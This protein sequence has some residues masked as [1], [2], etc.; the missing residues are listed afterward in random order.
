[1][2]GPR[3]LANGQQPDE[4]ARGDHARDRVVDD[5]NQLGEISH[6]RHRDRDV[7][8]PVAEPVHVVSLEAGV[9][10]RGSRARRHTGHPAADRARPS[11][12][13]Q[14]PSAATPDGGDD[15][16]EDGDAADLR[17]VDRK[18]EHAGADHVAGHEHRGLQ[19]STSSF[20]VGSLA[21][22][23]RLEALDV[24]DAVAR[25]DTVRVVP[26]AGEALVPGPQAPAGTR[27]RGRHPRP[28]THLASAS[29]FPVD[30]ARRWWPASDRPVPR[31]ARARFHRAPG[32]DRP[33]SATW[34]DRAASKTPP[35]ASGSAA[36]SSIDRT[37]GRRDRADPSLP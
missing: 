32:V 27:G 19:Q 9:R 1:M 11:L 10:A 3:M 31:A 21:A 24:L 17:K 22:C 6:G 13:K 35:R 23:V 5:R 2:R 29:E 36:R 28:W 14:S 12:A 30:R 16:A 7:A 8:D 37:S 33:R 26:E 25:L 34:R 18:Q 4:E 15:P 20:R